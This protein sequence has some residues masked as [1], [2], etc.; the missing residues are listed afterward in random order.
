M[1]KPTIIVHGGAWA[2]PAELTER[3]LEGVKVAA[4]RGQEVMTRGG[5]AVDAVVAAVSSLEDDT[6]FDAGHGAVLNLKGEVELDAIVVDGQTMD[7]GAVCGL[8]GCAHPVQVARLVMDKT[9][10]CLLS[11]SGANEFM[12][13]QGIARVPESELVTPEAQEEWKTYVQFSSAVKNLFS[14]RSAPPPP[15]G[16]DTVGAVAMDANGNL[17]AATSTGGITAKLPGRVGDS[18]IIG[19]GA[20]ADSTVG[21]ASTTGHGESIMK[22]GLARRVGEL[23]EK[24]ETAQQAAEHALDFMSRRVGG[25]AGVIVLSKGGETGTC[26]VGT[27]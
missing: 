7:S 15:S 16:C 27:S 2:I 4:C 17:A 20:Y 23:L 5:S 24:G 8:Q 11:G 18:P 10:H 21:A 19:A 13:A 3:S 6:A 9:S 1:F 25:A 14:E 12:Q 26:Q 22:V